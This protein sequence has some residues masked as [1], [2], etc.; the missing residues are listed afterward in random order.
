MSQSVQEPAFRHEAFFYSGRESFLQGT[1][2]FIEAAVAAKEPILV[3]VSAA[4]IALL[5]EALN[6]AAEHACFADMADVGHNPAR[7]IPAWRQFVSEHSA[8]GRPFRGIGE[9][10]W[11]GRSPAEL[12]ECQVHESLLNLTFAGSAEW[13]LLCPYDTDSLDGPILDEARRSHPYVLERGLGR[14]SLIY[15]GHDIRIPSGALP[16]PSGPTEEL[17]FG[18]GP[19]HVVRRFVADHAVRLGLSS[20][21]AADLVLAVNELV[22]NSLCHADGRGILRLWADGPMVVC[23][24]SDHGRIDQPLIGRVAPPMDSDGGRGVWLANQVCDLV[25]V[26]SSEAGTVVRVHLSPG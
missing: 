9:P 24:V 22:T 4:K 14:P 26:R 8:R 7:I 17:A 20:D 18:A 10:I 1:V 5:R 12:V 3:V 16:E 13:W 25:Q 2:P 11:A 21:R 15:R 6:G 23:E 19:L